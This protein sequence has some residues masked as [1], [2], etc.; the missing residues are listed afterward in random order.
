MSRATLSEVAQRAGVSTA[1]ASLAL[2]GKAGQHRISD[3]TYQRV[4]RAADELDY[5]P[6]LLVR[7]LQQ[8]RTQ[9][10]SFFN[11][12]RRERASDDQYLARLLVAIEASAGRHGYDV[13]THCHFARSPRQTYEFLSGGHAD[14]VLF[15]APEPDDPLLPLLR[16]SRL[17]VVLL[18]AVDDDGR[19]PSVRDD[20]MGGMAL[21]ADELIRL[22][23]RRIAIVTER[24]EEHKDRHERVARLRIELLRHDVTVPDSWILPNLHDHPDALEALVNRPDAPTALF[25]WRD[26]IAYFLLEACEARGIAVPERLS[27]LGYD[28]VVWPAATRHA[29]AS[30]QV[31]LEGLA[32]TA[33][34]LLD[35]RLRE[36]AIVPLPQILPV[37][38]TRGTTLGAAPD[39]E[40]NLQR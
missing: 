25:C 5:S 19:L 11:A 28:G 39:P 22:G 3:E 4:R 17:P 7:S 10:L 29:A 35:Q 16:S 13:L 15:F 18:N 21:V 2:R 8:G 27:I 26:R 37:T 30:V 34:R 40:R 14:G 32:E 24:G 20:V 1:T 12:F 31:D 9:I 33:I 38:L 23:H 6:N 36:P